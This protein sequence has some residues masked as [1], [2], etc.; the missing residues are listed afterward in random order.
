MAEFEPGRPV[1]F[2]GGT[3]LPMD[4]RRT[5]LENADVLLVGE[6]IEAVGPALDV[7][8]ER[9]RSTPPAASCCRA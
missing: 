8:R 1:A 9:S 4:D 7:P 6:R 5:V 2:R 3:V